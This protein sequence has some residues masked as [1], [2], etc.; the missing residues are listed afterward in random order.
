M[1]RLSHTLALAT[2]LAFAAACSNPETPTSLDLSSRDATNAITCN[3]SVAAGTMN[4]DSPNP[5]ARSGP[6]FSVSL[7]GQNN[8]VLLTSSG[9]AY[10]NPNFTASV[11]L[12]N[13]TVQPMGTA[14]GTAADAGGIKVFFHSGPTCTAGGGTATVTPNDGTGNFT[15]TSQPYYQYTGNLAPGAETVNKTWTFNLASGCTQFTF[16]VLVNS[17]LPQEQGIL[18]WD[19]V[20][21]GTGADLTGVSTNGT[22]VWAVGAN[23]TIVHYN[24]SSWSTQASGH[25][26]IAIR[27]V[28]M[29]GGTTT[30]GVA[31]GDSGTIL[32]YN[33]ST[34]TDALAHGTAALLNV[35]KVGDDGTN[36]EWWACGGGG[37]IF[38]TTDSSGATGWVQVT[39]TGTSN[40]LHVCGG[41]SQ[42]NVYAIGNGG[43]IT[44]WAGSSWSTTGYTSNTTQDLYS[45]SGGNNN[46]YVGGANGTILSS[47][48]T[49][50]TTFTAMTSG[51]GTGVGADTTLYGGESSNGG[52]PYFVGF[53]GV[54]VYLN[55]AGTTWLRMPSSTTQTLNDITLS[56]GGGSQMQ[57]W[58]VGNGGLVLHG[59]R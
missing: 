7:G 25:S 42:T 32:F 5:S 47:P 1:M 50:G 33:G 38:H 45:A 4:C 9:T 11:K 14:N 31:V 27:A 15:G 48:E 43:V 54:I 58:V 30:R 29:H 23:G 35:S 26:A 2:V 51:I 19:A 59:H 49:P 17:V 8:L 56:G 21:A 40:D 55:D 57:A 28:E 22:E 3:V 36:K 52:N 16:Q 53:G 12:K 34:W 20:N 41:P 24:G 46:I 10:N 37:A 39:P 13:L 18:K 6:N 44:H